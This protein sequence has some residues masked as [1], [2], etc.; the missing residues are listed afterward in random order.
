MAIPF[1]SANHLAL[2]DFPSDTLTATGKTPMYY[3]LAGIETRGVGDSVI[4]FW[5]IYNFNVGDVFM[6][7][8]DDE[9]GGAG[10]IM[11]T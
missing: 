10:P 6:Y 5:S 4:N 7:L 9:G 2:L 3:N 11:V 8:Q 1:Y